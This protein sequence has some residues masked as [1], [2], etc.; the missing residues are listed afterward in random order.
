MHVLLI[1]SSKKPLLQDETQIPDSRKVLE[2]HAVQTI[3]LIHVMHGDIQATHIL[4][5]VSPKYPAPQS[6]TQTPDFKNVLELH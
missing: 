4:L 3:L 1:V 2:L 5:L 6:K